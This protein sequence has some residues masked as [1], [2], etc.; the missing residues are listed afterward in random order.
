MLRPADYRDDTERVEFGELHLFVGPNFV[1]TVRHGDT[2]DL[3]GVRRRLE[4]RPHLLRLGSEA[5]LSP[6]LM[7]FQRATR[8]LLDSLSAGFRR[9]KFSRHHRTCPGGLC[10]ASVSAGPRLVDPRQFGDLR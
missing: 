10:R 5:V 9:A 6:E 7:E 3:T 8:M 1:L 2:P 4:A